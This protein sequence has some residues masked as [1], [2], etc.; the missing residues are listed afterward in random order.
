MDLFKKN[1][2]KPTLAEMKRVEIEKKAFEL[3]LEVGYH[4][5]SEI[6]WVKENIVKLE[7]LANSLGL[8]DIVSEKYIQ[9]KGEGGLARE[10]GLNI[11][12]V[13][14]AL[15][16]EEGYSS[17]DEPAFKKPE[18]KTPEGYKDYAGNDA[19]FA[20]VDRP[21]LLTSPSCISLTKAVERPANLDGFK[22][23]MPKK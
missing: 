13:T 20:P 1:K 12:S 22:P 18:E 15:K 9:G 19:I 6:G 2:D 23:L 4:K 17:A 7:T 8:G 11:G 16:K 3:G 14:S 21:E 5:H 10:K